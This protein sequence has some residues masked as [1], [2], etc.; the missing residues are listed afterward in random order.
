MVLIGGAERADVNTE[1]GSFNWREGRLC[2]PL[3][4]CDP[5]RRDLAVDCFSGRATQL[6]SATIVMPIH[7]AGSHGLTNLA[8]AVLL[9]DEPLDDYFGLLS[10]KFS[11]ANLLGR[12]LMAQGMPDEMWRSIQ[13][14]KISEDGEA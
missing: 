8:E 1:A 7:F 2:R 3:R 11:L 4:S 10:L 9:S 5:N 14:E 12:V 6:P 13:G